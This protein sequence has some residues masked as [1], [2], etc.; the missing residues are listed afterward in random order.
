MGK[1]FQLFSHKKKSI[2]G[3]FKALLKVNTVQ[4][5]NSSTIQIYKDNKVLAMFQ[6]SIYCIFFKWQPSLGN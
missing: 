5:L 4:K 2:L 6:L 3:P 1:L